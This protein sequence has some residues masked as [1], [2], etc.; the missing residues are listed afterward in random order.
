MCSPNWDVFF[1][2]HFESRAKFYKAT[3]GTAG[4]MERREY[5]CL[6]D[7]GRRERGQRRKGEQG[8]VAVGVGV[9]MLNSARI[10][11]TSAVHLECFQ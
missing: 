10:T 8:S 7:A 5:V 2:P 6:I 11:D 1:F 3:G 4:Q 9:N